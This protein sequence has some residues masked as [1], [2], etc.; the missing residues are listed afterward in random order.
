MLLIR[1]II[2]FTQKPTELC[3][4]F[5]AERIAQRLFILYDKVTGCDSNH[6]AP[7]PPQKKRRQ[8]HYCWCN[9][10]D[11]KQLFREFWIQISATMFI[12]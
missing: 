12:L 5:P 11:V 8:S 7:P 10:L 4:F 1:I 2:S 6:Y 3:L 9:Y